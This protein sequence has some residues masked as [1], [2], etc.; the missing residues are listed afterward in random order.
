[1]DKDV[2]DG[3]FGH[4]SREFGRR[5]TDTGRGNG[6]NFIVFEATKTASVLFREELVMDLIQ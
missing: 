4:G 5:V 2:L 6:F 1:M 3:L